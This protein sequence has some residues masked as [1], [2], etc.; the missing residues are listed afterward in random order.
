MIAAVIPGIEIR[1][2]YRT[3]PPLSFSLTAACVAAV[4]FYSGNKKIEAF[5]TAPQ[6]AHFQS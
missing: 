2:Y 6:R 5:D 3:I 4:S 1:S